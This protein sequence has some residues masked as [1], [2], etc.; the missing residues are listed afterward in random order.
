M[1]IKELEEKLQED[2]MVYFD[3]YGQ[4]S[5]GAESVDDLCKII[6]NN[7]AI[8]RAKNEIRNKQITNK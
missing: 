4:M 5:I 3:T 8:H 2:I 1:T 6:I 7:F